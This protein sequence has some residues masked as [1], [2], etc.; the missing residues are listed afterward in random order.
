M[1]LAEQSEAMRGEGGDQQHDQQPLGRSGEQ[2]NHPA[3]AGA[4]WV[5]AST[6]A[7]HVD[8]HRRD[9]HVGSGQMVEGKG[10][11]HRAAR[12]GALCQRHQPRPP[13]HPSL[14]TSRTTYRCNFKTSMPTGSAAS[15]D[16]LQ[17]F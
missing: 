17:A 14:L 15:V 6:P 12:F 16:E 1:P 7:A 4:R 2:T 10:A 3:N 11:R 5:M 8:R 13:G 9:L